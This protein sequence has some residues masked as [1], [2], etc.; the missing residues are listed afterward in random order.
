MSTHPMN[1][2]SRGV[3]VT[4]GARGIGAAVATRFARAGDRV[5]VHYS[6]SADDAHRLVRSLPG[7]GHVALRADLGTVGAARGLVDEAVR[8]LE[9]ID[10][11][12]NNAAVAPSAETLHRAAE[13]SAA[14]WDHVWSRMSQVNLLAPAAI[15]HAVAQH[16]IGRGAPGAIVNVGS[17][18]A[19]RGEPDHPA[20][21]A[22]KAALHAMGQSMAVALAPHGI[23]VASVAPGFVATERQ[24]AKLFDAGEQIRAQSPW[25]RVGSPEEIA[26]AVFFLASPEAV[27]ASG[28]VL[29]MNGASHLR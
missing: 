21:G 11:L 16:L 8:A 24:A 9:T 19:Y 20:Y 7:E 17:R 22:T 6:S 13:T 4:G 2:P 3:L 1:T 14:E 28:A 15:S 5:A 25:G 10:V 26:D 12:V 27:W 29:D 23:A 18:G